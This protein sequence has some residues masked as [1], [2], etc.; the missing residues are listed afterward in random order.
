MRLRLEV[1][2]AV[3][4]VGFRPFVYRLAVELGLGG[5]VRNSSRGVVVEV[6]GVVEQLRTFERRL[7]RER[8]PLSSIQAIQVTELAPVGARA[9]EIRSSLG[10]APTAVVLPDIATCRDCLREI[11]DRRDRRYRYPFTNC[12]RCGPRFSIIEALPYDRANTTMRAFLMCRRCREEF[13]DPRNRRFHAQPNAC[14]ECGPHLEL[15]NQQGRVLATHHAALLAA[16]EALRC[17]GIVALKGVGGFQLL[18]DARQEQV[19][20]RLRVRKRREEKPFALMVPTLETA[21]RYCRVSRLEQRLLTSPPNHRSCCCD[22]NG[23][24]SSCPMERATPPS[25]NRWRPTTPIWE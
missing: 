17:G 16:A 6:E 11:F 20:Q 25:R 13:E 15:W 7:R 8:P 9:F 22:G 12:T 14:P 21:R 23:G 24:R 19:V 3:Q 1:S 2:G 10:G 5:W 18:A 4:G